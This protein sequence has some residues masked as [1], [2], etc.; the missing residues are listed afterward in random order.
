MNRPI[1]HAVRIAWPF[2][3]DNFQ[4]LR[5]SVV[6]KHGTSPEYSVLVAAEYDP[7]GD[8]LRFVKS[9]MR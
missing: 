3:P 6:P 5:G 2:V 8:L 4:V 1:S 7:V 9:A